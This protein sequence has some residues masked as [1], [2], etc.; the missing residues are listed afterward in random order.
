[1]RRQIQASRDR[2]GCLRTEDA[3]WRE[4]RSVA[5]DFVSAF[6]VGGPVGFSCDLTA[7]SDEHQDYFRRM[8]A[9]RKKD[10]AFWCAAVGRIL[11]DMPEVVVLQYSD[12]ALKD[13]RVIV[14]TDR[15]RQNSTTVYPVLDPSLDYEYKG[16]IEKGAFWMDQGV[17]VELTF[18]D[19]V[20]IRFAPKS[21][22]Q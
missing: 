17:A 3:Y 20:Q 9:E 7:F 8:V 4:M 10:E 12:K 2:A 21:C 22:G 16:R 5:P 14:A 13:V 11:C 6:A 15:S 19:A 18:A 1:M